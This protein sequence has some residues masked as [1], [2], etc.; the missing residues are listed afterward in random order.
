MQFG[1]AFNFMTMVHQGYPMLIGPAATEFFRPEAV[2][3]AVMQLVHLRDQDGRSWLVTYQVQRQ[4]D[5]SWRIN[6]CLVE[7]DD[8]KPLI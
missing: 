8:G 2:E 5:H 4:P 7:S 6:G 3:D 1:N